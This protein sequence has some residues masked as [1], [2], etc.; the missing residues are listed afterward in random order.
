M[1]KYC[2][3]KT[4]VPLLFLLV[5][6]VWL[7]VSLALP[8]TSTVP[9]SGPGTFSN[10]I[11]IIMMIAS[12]IV[13]FQEV[14]AIRHSSEETAASLD[15]KE[16]G[17]ILLLIAALVLYSIFLKTLGFI[18]CSLILAEIS[19]LLFGQRKPLWL[20]VIPIG[21]TGIIYGVFRFALHILLPTIWL[22]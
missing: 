14:A 11:L 21:F 15:K 10:V 5:G 19:L 20:I 13:F 9:G 16:I 6:I 7:P 2:S 18:I 17:R 3:A 12:V 4:L 8:N 22:P 1:K